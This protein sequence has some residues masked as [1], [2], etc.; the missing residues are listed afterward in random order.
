MTSALFHGKK[1]TRII[2][3]MSTGFPVPTFG[4][5]KQ[6]TRLETKRVWIDGEVE[7]GS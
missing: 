4:F 2:S 6:N 7:Q 1:R 5:R 3:I